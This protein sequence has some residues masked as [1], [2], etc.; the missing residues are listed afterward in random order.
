M[1]WSVSF[2]VAAVP[3]GRSGADLPPLA[4]SQPFLF[5]GVRGMAEPAVD[6]ALHQAGGFR[7]QGWRC[8]G[9][10]WRRPPGCLGVPP[11]SRLQWRRGGRRDVLLGEDDAGAHKDLSVILFVSGLVCKT[12]G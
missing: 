2:L 11:S 6:G 1:A 9:A 4:R 3:S 7:R 8:F 12:L 10:E 5:V